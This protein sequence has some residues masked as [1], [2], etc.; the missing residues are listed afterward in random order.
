VGLAVAYAT[1]LGYDA[2]INVA[3]GDYTDSPDIQ[4]TTNVVLR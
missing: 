2:T 3:A 4:I 1:S